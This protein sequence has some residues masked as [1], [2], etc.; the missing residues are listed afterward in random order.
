MV[1]TENKMDQFHL[2]FSVGYQIKSSHSDSVYSG[3]A[4]SESEVLAVG[5]YWCGRIRHNNITI[6]SG[7]RYWRNL[8]SNGKIPEDLLQ[9]PERPIKLKEV[10]GKGYPNWDLLGDLNYLLSGDREWDILIFTT[11][12]SWGLNLNL[13]DH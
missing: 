3:G 13:T 6:T 9:V 4:I 8:F 1:V 2:R 5:R 11:L 10:C 7:C 12:S